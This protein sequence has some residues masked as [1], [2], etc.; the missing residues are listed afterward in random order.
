M[1]VSRSPT[2]IPDRTVT[3]LTFFDN[4][5]NNITNNGAFVATQRFNVSGL[6]DMDPRIASTAIAGFTQYAAFYNRYRALKVKYCIEGVNMEAFPLQFIVCPLNDDPGSNNTDILSWR[7][8]PRSKMALLSS[9]GGLDRAELSGEFDL[10]AILG[11]VAQRTDSIFS[12]LVTSNPTDNIFLGYGVASVGGN[13][14]TSNNGL[15]YVVSIKV[16]V[17]FYERKFIA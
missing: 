6:Y 16:Q 15:G 12:A 2:L 5:Y 9:K 13:T 4:T 1:I 17:E 7:M 14:L 10:A 8:N 11:S 3:E